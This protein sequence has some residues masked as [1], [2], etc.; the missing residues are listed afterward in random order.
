MLWNL[1]L[2]PSSEYRTKPDAL[3][4][5]ISVAG[6]AQESKAPSERFI[7]TTNN[8]GAMRNDRTCE[9]EA[10]FEYCLALPDFPL[11]LT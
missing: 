10:D 3:N 8:N 5:L 6:P 4:R 2:L 1:N 7:C 11:S 9:S